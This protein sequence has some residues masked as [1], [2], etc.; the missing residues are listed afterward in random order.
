VR[1]RFGQL[2]TLAARLVGVLPT[3]AAALGDLYDRFAEDI[4]RYLYCRT[5]SPAQAEEL[6]LQVFLQ[7]REKVPR[8]CCRSL[9]AWLLSLAERACAGIDS[10]HL[11]ASDRDLA[12][13]E[14][15]GR[16]N[17]LVLARALARASPQEREVLLLK[18]VCRLG[19]ETIALSLG[20]GERAVCDLQLRGLVGL[21]TALDH[22]GE[23]SDSHSRW[24]GPPLRA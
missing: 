10:D 19:N 23:Q 4:Y 9:P 8:K 15:R 3:E 2:K 16:L 6:M 5:G 22:I 13:L 11:L 20:M 12:G 24:S 17:P 21:R 7:A 14:V 1:L 18:F